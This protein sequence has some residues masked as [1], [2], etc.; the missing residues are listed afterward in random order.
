MRPLQRTDGPGRGQST[1]GVGWGGGGEQG[2][3]CGEQ[4]EG[5]QVVVGSR[6]QLSSGQGHTRPGPGHLVL[7]IL[8]DPLMEW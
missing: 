3:G 4:N 5:T 2:L 6:P 7:A 8:S 1:E